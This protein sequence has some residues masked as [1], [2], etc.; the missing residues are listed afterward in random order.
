MD[1]STTVSAWLR[2]GVG[3]AWLRSCDTDMCCVQAGWVLAAS[4]DKSA[5]L[6]QR[7]ESVPKVTL[8]RR[9]R[10]TSVSAGGSVAPK[11]SFFYVMWFA[12][13]HHF[14]WPEV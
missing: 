8:L 4:Y 10:E 9:L 5:Q 12:I 3:G 14:D 1:F 2:L 11:A 7:D 13:Y 6:W